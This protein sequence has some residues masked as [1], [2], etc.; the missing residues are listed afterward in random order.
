M[1]VA[2]LFLILISDATMATEGDREDS[3]TI[4]L[5]TLACNLV[6]FSLSQ[7]LKEIWSEKLSI[8]LKQEENSEL[9]GEKE[10][11]HL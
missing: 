9:R 2:K 5:S 7:I 10:G 11:K 8:I 6:S 1:K 4:S 3:K